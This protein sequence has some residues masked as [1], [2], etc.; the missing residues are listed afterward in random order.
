MHCFFNS[1]SKENPREGPGG[2]IKSDNRKIPLCASARLRGKIL[3]AASVSSLPY[4]PVFSVSYLRYSSPA[5]ALLSIHSYTGG[6]TS[7]P[8]SV[9]CAFTSGCR[10]SMYISGVMK[11]S[12]GLE[13]T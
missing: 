5:F 3:S 1:I 8:F 4:S 13:E 11:R 10:M 12:R 9:R 6:D 2:S 7:T